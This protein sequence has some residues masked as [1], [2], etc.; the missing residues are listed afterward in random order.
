MRV[1]ATPSGS[2]RD[3]IGGD[4][5]EN[6]IMRR[7]IRNRLTHEYLGTDGKWTRDHE[8]A[9]KFPDAMSLIQYALRLPEPD[10]DYVIMMEGDTPSPYDLI[11][12]LKPLRRDGDPLDPD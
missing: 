6:L 1:G 3:R 4:A 5:L 9:L 7:L 12:R 8:A 2:P 11:L 10:L